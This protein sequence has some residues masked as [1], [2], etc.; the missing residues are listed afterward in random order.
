MTKRDESKLSLSTLLV[1]ALTAVVPLSVATGFSNFERPRQA[2]LVVLA[3]VAL[4]AWAVGWVR[5]GRI[6]MASPGTVALGAAFLGSVALSLVWSGVTAF[7]ALS[8]LIWVSLG[9][10]FLILVAPV[11]KAPEFLDW[12]TAVGAGTLGAGGLG[13][14]ELFGGEGLAVV[15]APAGLTGGFDAMAFASAYYM[16]AVVLLIGGVAVS[17]GARRWFL[18]AALLSG[19]LH[20]GLVADTLVLG[21]MAASMVAMAVVVGLLTSA[22]GGR[23]SWLAAGLG[24]LVL[25]VAIGGS[26]MFDR[27]DAPTAADDLPRVS[28][29]GEFDSERAQRPRM[30]WWYFAADRVESYPDHRFRSYLNSVTRGLWQKEPIIGHGAGGWW[31]SQTDVVDISDPH[32]DRMFERYPAFKSPHNDYA[33][34]VVEQGA[35]GLILFVL[36]LLGVATAVGAGMRRAGAAGGAGQKESIITWALATALV[37]GAAAM[38][39]V[40][41]LELVSSAVVFV[42]AAALAVGEAAR[43]HGGHGWL[44][45]VTAGENTPWVRFGTV[46][47]SLVVAAAMVIPAVLHAKSALDRGYADHLMLMG[48]QYDAIELYES[49][50]ETYPAHAEV[51]YNIA[52]AHRVEGDREKGLELVEEALQMRPYDARFHVHA[53]E[54]Q[55]G[56]R[57]MRVAVEH[58]A[59][60][61]RT[62][63]RHLQGHEIYSSARQQRGEFTRAAEVLE[64]MVDMEPPS[65]D[66]LSVRI[67]LA[68]LY[69]VYLDEPEKARDHFDK[70]REDIPTGVERALIDD[71][72]EELE[73]RLEREFLEEEGL[74][75]PPELQPEIDDPH[76]PHHH[77]H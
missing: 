35:V 14:Y 54:I 32:V 74:P 28:A 25:A 30:S 65:D 10:V 17:R 13:L 40:P 47:V 11:G 77:H 50:H 24:V 6:E 39:F 9:V 5:R 49:A 4:I 63:P 41:L 45:V 66:R 2:V 69:S 1:L 52:V 37:I 26:M 59:E 68:T 71:R 33:R 56:E 73:Q 23:N 75:V 53:G 62:A 42:G 51:L 12:V 3:A 36:W 27:P 44:S 70:A 29:S 38:L 48:Q 31:L 43:R 58:G 16:V 57:R 22:E 21:V 15:W 67:Q 64:A 60:A 72:I 34:I 20:L 18:A 61:M 46:A 19:T 7:G 8:V 55:V 76:D